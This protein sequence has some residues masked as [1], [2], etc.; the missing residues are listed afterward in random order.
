MKVFGELECSQDTATPPTHGTAS[1][2]HL[3]SCSEQSASFKHCSSFKG[4]EMLLLMDPGFVL[5]PEFLW[6]D[7][8]LYCAVQKQWGGNSL[9]VCFS[10][11]VEQGWM[12]SRAV[13]C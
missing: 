6:S 3:E 5:L 1:V 13:L 8:L 10:I 2:Q 11:D 9:S 7:Y 12:I 4:R